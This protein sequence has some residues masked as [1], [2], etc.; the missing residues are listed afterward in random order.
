MKDLLVYFKGYVKESL[1]APVFK[2]LEAG[3]ELWVPL[4][5]AQLVDQIIP[6]KN[7]ASLVLMILF[8]SLL[9]VLGVLVAV[10]AQY[11]SAKSAVGY[12]EGLTQDLLRKVLALPKSSRDKLGAASLLTRL[13][14]D[15]YQIQTGI[16]L[17]LRLFL[18]APIIVLGSVIMAVWISP[19]TSLIFLLLVL[20]LSVTIF[21][22]SKVTS[23]LYQALRQGLDRILG[24]VS[25]QLT[26]LRTIRAFG[27]VDREKEEFVT[28]NRAYLQSQLR[29]GGLSALTSPLSYLLVNIALILVIWQ[30]N[31]A[32]KEGSLSPGMLVA[33][34]NYLLQIL[35]ELV[36]TTILVN[37]LNQAYVSA[38]RVQAV[39]ALDEEAIEEPLPTS[40]AEEGLALR[41]NELTY[42]HR[43]A[44]K[45]ALDG[46]NFELPSGGFM[47]IIGGT[48]AG[49]TS[50]IQLL[51]GLDSPQ[52]GEVTP[53][54]K[55]KSPETLKEWRNWVAVV[56]QKA[57]LFKGTVRT[58]L[59]LGQANL[60]LD[61]QELWRVLDMAQA[62]DF[63]REKG[64]LDS[65]VASFGR[66]FSG[67][68]RQRLTIARALLKKAPF[69]ILDDATSALDYLT[70]SRLLNR[71]GEE[72]T[73]TTLIMVSQRTRNLVA[74]EQ[75]LVLD[76]GKQVGL[77]RHEDLLKTSKIYRDIHQTQS[78]GGV[79]L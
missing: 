9:A 68:Q 73:D 31:L 34:V 22:I 5:I 65:P 74:A 56:P 59:L 52:R 10:T 60:G 7:Q 15:T 51:T 70:E 18:R 4:I 50:L 54:V 14:T 45:P 66:N 26:G 1:L 62:A 57:Q 41:I 55:G 47:G 77:G 46:L 19:P 76:K 36:K 11:F 37:Q 33:L 48:G 64:G 75:I 2:L 23:P 3:F 17:F 67:G 43:D 71:L 42:Q 40:I 6:N 78:K 63:I 8:L 69:L 61:D 58:N 38:K 49:K 44:N 16:N 30:G 21:L 72:L 24:L 20:F 79:G 29:T 39:F 53:F 28:L 13:S 25:Q 27:Q 12:T 32:I 35:A